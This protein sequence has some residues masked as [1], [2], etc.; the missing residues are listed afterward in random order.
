MK[1]ARSVKKTRILIADR[2]SVFR[3]GLLKL[4]GLEDDLRIVAQAD[5]SEQVAR[6]AQQFK[7]DVVLVQ[8]EILAEPPGNLAERVRSASGHCRIVITAAS[9]GQEL[10][11]RYLQ[12]GVSSVIQRRALPSRFV[13]GVRGALKGKA[14]KLEAP[15]VE[16]VETLEKS[17][18]DLSRPVDTLTQREK[19][20]ISYLVQ[21]CGNR[22]IAQHL[23]IAEQTVKNH[24]RAIF[25]KVGVSDRLELVLYAIHKRLELPP[26]ALAS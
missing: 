15:E 14:T 25:D 3:L 23:S 19:E 4:F 6:L 9:L 5:T 12:A 10:I 21:G 11:S 17:K 20:V 8:E 13:D 1:P 2:E 18:E 7:P 26:V 16:T 22:E 24:L